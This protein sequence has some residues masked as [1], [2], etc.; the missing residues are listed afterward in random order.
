MRRNTVIA[1]LLITATTLAGCASV[2]VTVN[3]DKA[4]SD[5]GNIS[6]I[7]GS[8]GP[9]FIYLSN[10]EDIPFDRAVMASG[11]SSNMDDY[12]SPEEA[13]FVGWKE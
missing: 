9:T 4:S 7:G 11:L 1:A 2:N 8:D 12:F 6:V 3:T 10:I 13:V 5:Q